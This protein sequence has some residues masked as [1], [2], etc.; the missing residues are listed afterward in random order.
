MIWQ[1][2]LA[3]YVFF[4]IDRLFNLESQYVVIFRFITKSEFQ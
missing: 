2:R 1:I 3:N 4:T